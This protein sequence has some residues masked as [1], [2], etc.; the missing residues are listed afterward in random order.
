M[1]SPKRIFLALS[2]AITR[3]QSRALRSLVLFLIAIVAALGTYT[4]VRAAPTIIATMTAAIIG[5]DGDNK[6]DP[7][8]IIEYTVT[9][10]NSGTDATGVVFKD[11]IDSNTTLVAGSLAAS[12]VA[13]NDTYPQTVV[14]HVSINSASI[15]YSVVTNDFLGL[16]P[17]AT[18]SAY[19]ATTTQGGQV[20]MT[21]SGLGIGQ[22]T[23]DPPR[24]FEGT[25]TFTYTLNNTT[26]SN[27]ATVS[28]TVAGMVWF[29]DNNSTCSS[30]CDG[31]LSHPYT[32]LADFNTANGL[33]GGLNPDNNDNIFIYES[34]TA[35][36]DGVT[37][38]QG[39]KLIGQDAT[40]SLAT[41]TGL[42]PPSG[43][44][45]FPVMNTGGNAAA[46]QNAGGNGVSATNVVP[47]A[48]RGLT[49]SGSV[50]AIDLTYSST[51]AAGTVEIKDNII[52]SSGVEGIDINKDGNFTLTVDA[53]NNTWSG[54]S[55]G[56]AFDVTK[57]NTA[58]PGT[59][60]LN[61][62]GNTNITSA[63]DA[64]F[65]DGHLGS[66]GAITITGFANNTVSGNTVGNGINI[67]T[68]N[69]DSNVGTSA[70]DTVSAGT[71]AIGASGNPVGGKGILM[72]GTSGITGD[73]DFTDLDIFST[74]AGL[75]VTGSGAVNT[76]AGTGFRMTM[77]AG[78]GTINASAGPA[79]AITNAT[80][81][82]P[83]ATLTSAN[84]STTGVLLTGINDGTTA[85]VFSAGAGSSITDATGTDFVINT[86]NATVTYNGT[87]SDSNGGQLVSASGNTGD[88]KTFT[89]AISNTGSSTGISLTSN[90]GTTINFSGALTLSTGANPAFTATGSGTVN[91][92]GTNTITTT[93]GTAVNIANTTIGSSNVTFQ[94]V[95]HN[96]N[97]TAI[98]LTNTGSGQF[99]VT[100]TGATAGSGGTIQNIVGADAVMLNTTG[101]LVTLK[102]MIIQ[103]IT[104]AGDAAAAND[105]RSGV[106]AIH[107]QTVNGGLTLDNVTIQ[108]ISDD[109]IN[110][111]VDGANPTATVF[112]GLTITNSTIQ[113]TNRF[114]V[115]SHADAQN[116]AAVYIFGIKGT[117]SV[118][119]STFQN[120][121]GGLIFQTDTSGTLD[122]TVQTNNFT[123]LYKEPGG[124]ASVGNW[125]IR[126]LQ[127]GS[128]NST[129]RIGDQNETNPAL[130]N[131]FTNGGSFASVDIITENT[132]T[133]NMKAEVSKNTFT[134]TDHT[135]PGLPPGNMA[136]NF[137]QG[138][139]LFRARGTGN[140]EG[141]FA[142]NLLDQVMHADGGLGQ[143]TLVAENGTTEYIVRNNTFQLPWDATVENRADGASGGQTSD[144]VLFTGNT[145]VDGN[146]GSASDDLGASYPSPYTPFYTQVRNNGRMDLTI[147]NENPFG[148]HDPSSG[149]SNSF[150]A[151]T[152]SAG[153]VLNLFLQ[154]TKSPNGYQLKAATGTTYN[155]YRNGSG[156]GTAQLV[157][158]DNGNTGGA[159]SD[160][161]TPPVMNLSGAGTVTLSNT[162]PTLPAIV[163]SMVPDN[164]HTLVQTQPETNPVAG[165]ETISASLKPA[166]TTA[167]VS[168]NTFGG[169]SWAKPQKSEPAASTRSGGPAPRLFIVRPAPMLSGETVNVNIGNLPAGKTVTIKYRVTVNGPSLPLGTT[170]ISNQG[171]VSYDV[172]QTTLTDDTAVVGGSDPTITLVDRP[173]T[174]VSSINLSGSSPTNA[175]SVSWTV[176]F[177][178]ATN[179]LTS[180]NFTLVNSGLGG[181]PAI[182]GVTAVGGV[183]ATQW[184]VTASTGT[185]DGTLGLNLVNDTGLGHDVP[186][187]PFT[188]QVYTIDRTP[189]SAPVILTPADGSIT[190]DSTP[191]VTGTA[192]ANSTVT[193]YLDGS[194]AGTTT[195]NG[196]G[197]W[198]F[199]SIS[200]LSE[201]SH[202]VKATATDA[203]G[204]T[205][206]DSATNTFTVDI[207]PPPAPLV[208][209]PADGSTTNDSA[210][211]VTGTAEANSTVTVYFDGSSAGT[212]TANGAG[213]W[214]FTSASSL[215]DGSHSV[216]ATATDAAGNTSVDSATNTF[217]VDTTPPTAPVL[218]TPADASSTNDTTPTVTG[219]AEANSTVT[220][221]F[222]GSSAGTTTANGA[223]NWT[224]TSASS[225]SD[226]SHSV[227]ATA[228]DAAGNTSVD[229]ATNTF[230]V[231][232]TPPTAPV[233]STP[234]DASS[235]NDT[236]PTVTGTAEANSTV[237][238]YF[239]GSSAGTTT[240]NGAGNWSFTSA[241]SL[242]DGA[243]TVKATATDALG[244][245]SVDSA[246]NTFTVDTTPPVAPVV[247]TPA[248]G[249]LTND[250]T[251]TVTGT[252]EANST[253]T[254][255]FDGSS[256]GTTTAN[257]AG[258]W[259]FTSAS[260]LSDGAHAVKATA[261]DAL[262]NTSVDSATNTFTVDT[263]P[264]TAPV[265]STPADASSTNDTTPTVTGTAEANSTVTVYF[266]GSSAGTTTA[267][268]AGNWSFTSASSLSDGA[269]TVK[270]TATDAAGNT[271]VDSATNTFTVDTTPPTAPVVLTPADGSLTNDTTPTVTGTAEAN[272]TVMIYFDGSSAGTTTANGAGSWAF[273]SASSLSD[274]A[275]TV[276]A[277]ATDA[278]GNTGVDSATN[279]F[280]VD[281]NNP[282]VL[283]ISSTAPNPT[284]AAS[285][286]VTVT[287]SESVTGFLDTDIVAVNGTV[288]N[289]AGSG[290]SYTFDL[291]PSGEGLVTADIAA[292]VAYDSAGNG[293]TAATQFSR[294]Y[295]SIAPTVAINQA[296]GQA[297]PTNVSPVNFTVV[298]SESM[299]GFATGDVTLS[300]T[301]GATTDTV[302]EIAPN[303]GT[304]YNV[305]VSGMTGDG[306]VIAAVAVNKAQ[307]AAGNGNAAFTSTDNTVTYDGTSPTVTINQATGQPDPTGVSPVNFS[308][309]FS[310]PVTGF[311]T[312]D[313]SLS[314]TTGATTGTVTEIAPNDGTTYNVAV[315]GMS[316]DGTIIANVAVN[317]AQDATGN[318]NAA[319]TNTD[320]S[321]VYDTVIPSVTINQAAGQ[322]DPTNVS[323]IHFTV[324]FSEPVTGF[325][326]GEVI[327]GGTVGA[328]TSAATEIAPNNGTTYDVAVSGMTGN[329]TVTASIAAGV[330]Q[331]AAAN[332]NTASSSTDNTITY[333]VTAPTVTINQ[334]TG[335]TDPT[336]VSPVNF[337]VV[338]SD[339]VTGFA[340]GDVTLSGTAGATTD[341]VTEI[342]PNDGTTYNVAVSGMATGGTIIA[343]IN[344]GVAQDLAGNGNAAF[345]STDNTVTFTFD[346]T[347]TITSDTPDPSLVGETVTFNYTVTVNAPGSGTPTG[348]V[349]VSDGANS[350]TDTVAAGSCTII[351]ATPGAKTLTAT[352]A[353]DTFFNGSTSTDISHQVNNANTTTT[354]TSDAP[355]PSIAGQ[356]V[357]V[358]FSV[359]VV[360]PASGTPTGNVT[361]SDGVD[362]CTGTVAS[363]ACSVTLTTPG[364]RTLT[365]TYAGDANF[366]GSASLGASHTV[367]EAPAITSANAAGFVINTAESFTVT[368]SGYPTGASMLIT[369]TG[370]LPSGVTFI[371]NGDG[372]ATLSGTATASGDFP[373]TITASNGIAPDATQNFTLTVGQAPAITSA[374]ATTFIVGSAGNFTITTTGFPNSALTRTGAL[375]SGVT[376]TDNGDGTAS[377][378]GTPVAGTG[379]T[380][381][382]T[383]TASN[384]VGANAT[385]NFTLTVNEA[386]AITSLNHATFITGTAGTFSITSTGF[387]A[388]GL[389]KT[390]SLPNNVTFTDNGN[391]TATLSGTATVSG[392]FPITITASNGVS[393]DATQNFTLTV[394]PAG[395][396]FIDVPLDYW[397][398]PYIASLYYAGITGGCG[399]SPLAYCPENSVTRAEMAVFLKRGI[400]G[401]SY[402]PPVVT[403]FFF[404]DSEGH[405]AQY[406][407]E[408]LRS[409]SFT[410]GCTPTTYCPDNPITRAQAAVFLLRLKHG[411]AYTPPP[412]SGTLFTDV[413]ADQWAAAWIEELANEGITSGCGGENFCP[414]QVV[415]RAQIAVL[416]VRTLGLP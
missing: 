182:T 131:T 205:S 279:T 403:T 11:T 47:A 26:G 125:G 380:Y 345:T 157:L 166:N 386:P 213:N 37:L 15:P 106:D 173:D 391:G 301:A 323:P 353:G 60:R 235:T 178:D 31:R 102:N 86:N 38:R 32:T 155:L 46:I 387:P 414:E 61:F 381:P 354:I 311:A 325:V 3:I 320:N 274:G 265:V 366:G 410:A 55:T 288:G 227:K 91:V 399:T 25:D 257:G 195:A 377:L 9:I 276:K 378:S 51:I 406:W 226:G 144:R 369:E 260:S 244:N 382:I 121:A 394:N 367:N 210:P 71:T 363:G 109:G 185:G 293:N 411:S 153:D 306:T 298:F 63:A 241:S 124:T 164:N 351:F 215:S 23:Y 149:F 169:A 262:G 40:V 228:T 138:G 292:D 300:G 48:I 120:A 401:S 27:T 313:V 217:T 22:F 328:I 212:T 385:Q 200:S 258:N 319:S 113:N 133:G 103:D 66:S 88:T 93:S 101:G 220:V 216:K 142:S 83:F 87:I 358:N 29:I 76:G 8:E 324:V 407:I 412:A 247:L 395:P 7:G 246:T 70:Y 143:L 170:Q 390:G 405:W 346:T 237:T 272:S 278:L 181:T 372:T 81:N 222:D 95:A 383:F 218:S 341:T 53:Q 41:I 284:N 332:G 374:D 146:V 362:S 275:H 305:S 108:R 35:Y 89:G 224:F 78:V 314:G 107:G 256:A 197:N 116:E 204:N 132:S 287:F 119:G 299:T 221:Y 194:S 404:M 158:Q 174:T 96:G 28:I 127:L 225:L 393:P 266:D 77:A 281:T 337:T 291:T 33:S 254:V 333:D 84:S 207:T 359:A 355:D 384:G 171:T 134:V 80:I 223:G 52:A 4:I 238:V 184:T 231:D 280:T 62:S 105:T 315:S 230:T 18:I 154:N 161:T 160:V 24:G 356:S 396:I 191:T 69:F 198:S 310:E 177:A 250:N 248:D 342:A 14:G 123:T 233:V 308:V 397:A 400:H 307:D 211:T 137:P 6:A 104:A 57:A 64:I 229:S 259:S 97:N 128:L 344:A 295:D 392:V 409:E 371:D 202:T 297:D 122:M 36:T 183:P 312:G 326:S 294:T 193:V 74:G 415:T 388:S 98:T 219:T 360:A 112:N 156:S 199:T 243:H 348:N 34:S 141:I 30:S 68:A 331:D 75:D 263:T 79:V 10:P 379:G 402:V 172:G 16:N 65:I 5:D 389:S 147:Q 151:Q 368:T 336:N 168:A 150:H 285:I 179:G 370:S 327:L 352:Y 339:A 318:G 12:P 140:Y 289:F 242:S 309:I 162:A 99:M 196:T 343:S 45:P 240:A 270:A 135:S 234:A 110:G 126:V 100:G 190:N 56:N 49:L 92:T 249:S 148:L 159:G 350:C 67:N 251:P 180:S 271:S 398:A 338:F 129:V 163:I 118:T 165:A 17:T 253:V 21:T 117:V 376:F 145:Y 72:A 58:T 201:G 1:I 192:E 94:S 283:S 357:T 365:A 50:N 85:S 114:N 413:P 187:L 416:L 252:A 115:A 130:A 261:T 239:D 39:Q 335:Q 268:G 347:T 302:T 375:P 277:A 42:T 189:P 214:T 286:P 322:A 13:G 44:A 206:V 334:A 282:I 317:K 349:T 264:P 111:S 175:G 273:T 167:S 290:A 19:D 54:A 203:V 303:D 304:T 364:L 269:H 139:V 340:T 152:T 73:L 321:V 245:T 255:Y 330:A 361:V 373:I 267:N 296:S 2:G 176:T 329:G 20:S 136:F 208:L 236:T 209:T 316:S 90:T 408:D 82:L 43:S 186:I 59:V 232:T 188:G